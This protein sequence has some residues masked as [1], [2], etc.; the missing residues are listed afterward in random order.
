MAPCGQALTQSWQNMQEPKSYSYFTKNFFF[1][2]SASSAF[3]AL[4]LGAPGNPIGAYVATMLV[5]EIVSAYAGKTKLDIILVPLGAL[6]L[7]FAGIFAAYPF[8]WLIGRLG[9]FI[10]FATDATPFVMGIV[11]SVVMGI[12]LTMHLPPPYGFPWRI[13]CFSAMPRER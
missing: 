5:V 7:S 12:V 1:F 9:D 8:I 6:F 11:I 3:T 10:A 13:P 2:P 4:K